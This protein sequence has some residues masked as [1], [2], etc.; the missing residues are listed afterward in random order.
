VTPADLDGTEKPLLRGVH[1]MFFLSV[2]LLE[3]HLF[4]LPWSFHYINHCHIYY[5]GLLSVPE[6]IREPL[7]KTIFTYM[8]SA[9]EAD[10][11][12]ISFEI[13]KD[14]SNLGHDEDV[15]TD[16]QYVVHRVENNDVQFRRLVII[17]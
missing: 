15:V 14:V 16:L 2:L 12:A 1:G 17:C 10:M 9:G 13:M 11:A 4:F 8:Q 5:V 3:V 7:M 6:S